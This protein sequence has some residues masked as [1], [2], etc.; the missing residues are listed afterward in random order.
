MAHLPLTS[1]PDL[2]VDVTLEPA[3]LFG[4]VLITLDCFPQH[5]LLH[6]R[7]GQPL[8]CKTIETAFE[9][10]QTFAQHGSVALLN[11][12]QRGQTYHKGHR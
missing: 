3:L 7:L 2:F 6:L 9:L 8:L 12:S 11:E 4:D 10:S 1:S 5:Q